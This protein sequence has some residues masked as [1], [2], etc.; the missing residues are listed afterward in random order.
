MPDIV[1]LES[2]ECDYQ[3]VKSKRVC[4]SKILWCHALIIMAIL[5]TIAVSLLYIEFTDLGSVNTLCY[6]FMH[7]TITSNR[8]A[9]KFEISPRAKIHILR[10]S[11]P[12]LSPIPQFSPSSSLHAP[13][14]DL[15][16]YTTKTITIAICK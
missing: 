1:N 6:K 12:L 9:T 16:D 7:A 5:V 11:S 2:G 4:S 10:P 13:T 3:Q 15:Q 8:N 14:A